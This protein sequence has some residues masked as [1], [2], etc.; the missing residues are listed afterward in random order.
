VDVE[1]VKVPELDVNIPGAGAG[2]MLLVLDVQ[3]F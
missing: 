2:G 1:S 3:K